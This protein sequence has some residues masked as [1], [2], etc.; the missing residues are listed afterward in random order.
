MST[1]SGAK[2]WEDTLAV[3]VRAFRVNRSGALRDEGYS[4]LGPGPLAGSVKYS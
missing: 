1:K 4:G 3:G 2:R